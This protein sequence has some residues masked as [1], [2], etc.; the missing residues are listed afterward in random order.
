MS[1]L[2]ARYHIGGL[3]VGVVDSFL[4]LFSSILGQ[5]EGGTQRATDKLLTS[6]PEAIRNQF[7]KTREDWVKDYNE[8]LSAI[9]QLV[10]IKDS[11][12]D[13]VKKLYGLNKDLTTKMEGAITLYKQNPDERYKE[14]YSKL[15][16]T[17]EEA[18]GKIASLQEEISEQT[19]LIEQYKG[20]LAGL[21]DDIEKLKKEEAETVADIVS[22]KK[23]TELNS[24]LQGISQNYQSKNLEVIRESRKL[25]KSEA[26]LG[27]ELT[28][29]NKTSLDQKLMGAGKVSKHLD[30]FEK[31]VKLD[32]IFIDTPSEVKRLPEK[33]ERVEKKELFILEEKN[34][35][36]VEKK[37]PLDDLFN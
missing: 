30:V 17:K 9:S 25:I 28:G 34:E 5:A 32:T 33:I 37:K 10:Q 2:W 21:K 11:K 20:R 18:E 31:A 4:R 23:I 35:K 1:S 16:Y 29:M 3:T 12:E 14:E 19:I 26:K 22:S 15:A 36:K 8:M 24:K 27:S 13:E 7:R 6:S